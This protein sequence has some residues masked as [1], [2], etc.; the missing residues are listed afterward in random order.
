M[1]Q[2]LYCV[3]PEAKEAAVALRP[4]EEGFST[5][6][7]EAEVDGWGSPWA[8]SR[9]ALVSSTGSTDRDMSDAETGEEQQ[10]GLSLSE[11]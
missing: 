2:N 11:V 5:Q 3:L 1:L 4:E 8:G 10:A 7:S 9:G 6:K